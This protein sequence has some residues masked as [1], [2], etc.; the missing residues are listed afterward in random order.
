MVGFQTLSVEQMIA[1]CTKLPVCPVL[2]TRL[3][4]AL[5]NPTQNICD[6]GEIISMDPVLTA[7]VLKAAN[8]AYYGLSRTVRSVDDAII[9]LGFEEI[10]SVAAAAKAREMFAATNQWEGFGDAIWSH[11]LAT[12]VF[13]R[14]LARKI[15]ARRVEDAYY[16]AALL[17]DFGKLMFSQIDISYPVLCNYGAI[18]GEPLIEREMQRYGATHA[19]LGGE[20]LRQ[21]RLPAVLVSAVENHHQTVPPSAVVE[22]QNLIVT[23]ADFLAH[24]S[25]QTCVNGMVNFVPQLPDYLATRLPISR[26][27]LTIIISESARQIEML[28]AAA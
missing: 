28:D 3:T 25:Q 15:V 24:A 8:S 23:A 26:D 12:A 1:R 4:S 6:L 9:R 21:W 27:D 11:A 5:Q 16:T 2:F 10:F 20:L 14:T 18:H 22:P 17:H 13:A 19:H 7:K